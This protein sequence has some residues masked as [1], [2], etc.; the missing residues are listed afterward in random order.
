MQFGFQSPTWKKCSVENL[1]RQEKS[2]KK[3]K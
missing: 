3:K 1:E 2:K